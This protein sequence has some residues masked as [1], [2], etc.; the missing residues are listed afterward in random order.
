MDMMVVPS[1]SS[2]EGAKPP[3]KKTHPWPF[4]LV[5]SWYAHEVLY[6]LCGF[7]IS[8]FCP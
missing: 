3:L 7:C 5:Y 2:P 4:L 1:S 8:C 6:C